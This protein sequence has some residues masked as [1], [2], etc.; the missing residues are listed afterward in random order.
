MGERVHPR[1]NTPLSVWEEPCISPSWTG[2]GGAAGRCWRGHRG[3]LVYLRWNR[4]PVYI[5]TCAGSEWT[6][7]T[8]LFLQ[9]E[10]SWSFKDVYG[11]RVGRRALDYTLHLVWVWKITLESDSS[12]WRWMCVSQWQAAVIYTQGR[13]DLISI[14]SMTFLFPEP[15]VRREKKFPLKKIKSN[16]AKFHLV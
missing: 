1:L 10:P 3:P 9:A 16:G 13:E 11:Y 2:M 8:D 6:S 7:R 4:C 15:A 12:S 14:W 5:P